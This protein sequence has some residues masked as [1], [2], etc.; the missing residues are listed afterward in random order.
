MKGTFKASPYKKTVQRYIPT[1]GEPSWD[2]HNLSIEERKDIKSRIKV[3]YTDKEEDYQAVIA[4]LYKKYPDLMDFNFPDGT[5]TGNISIQW[6]YAP[7]KRK[8]TVENINP[9]AQAMGCHKSDMYALIYYDSLTNEPVAFAGS[10]FKEHRNPYPDREINEK[11]YYDKENDTVI[12]G[13]GY[14]LFIDPNYRRMGIAV[15]SWI[16]EAKIYRDDLNVMYQ[17]ELQNEDSLRVTQSMF[18]SPEKCNIVAPGRLKNDG[19][20]AGIRLL[21]DYT[22]Q[23]LIK[24][25]VD[26]EENMKDVYKPLDW[27]FLEREGLT[28]EEL[29]EPWKK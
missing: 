9:L 25:W 15:D 5:D 24:R 7:H 26:M 11:Y 18:S 4:Y 2:I 29:I 27:T 13:H 22:D 17:Y 23:D 1:I 19:T 16:T 20:R 28:K 12:E 21:M 3:G 8:A 6:K 10:Y 14:V